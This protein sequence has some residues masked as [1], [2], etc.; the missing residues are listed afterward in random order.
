MRRYCLI[1]IKGI[2]KTTLIK[3]ILEEIPNIDYFIG[4]QILRQLVGPRFDN[5][6][7][8]P[9][10]EKQ[11]Y[12]EKAIEYMIKRQNETQ[13][14]IL[15]DGHTTLY[16]PISNETENVFTEL[17]CKF[18]TDL[19]LYEVNALT[20][21]ERRKSDSIKK[22]ILDLSIIKKELSFERENSDNIA[23]KYGMQLHYLN[24]DFHNNLN[25][26]LIKILKGEK[27]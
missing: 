21:L 24:E 18:F 16:N 7:Y 20:V 17:D 4:S 10:E 27:M 14:D 5:F 8:F 9:K 15:V 13:K 25:I 6:D 26:E 1:G 23:K 22:R 12:R 2:G 19:I 11:K 3:T